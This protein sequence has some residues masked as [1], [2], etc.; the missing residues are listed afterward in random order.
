LLNHLN[1]QKAKMKYQ[2]SWKKFWQ[3]KNKLV[4]KKNELDKLDWRI[5]QAEIVPKNLFPEEDKSAQGE[6]IVTVAGFSYI[7]SKFE[8]FV[9]GFTI[10]SITAM[11]LNISHQSWLEA[12]NI[13]ERHKPF[14][15]GTNTAL[16]IPEE[17]FKDFFNS[18]EKRMQSYIFA[19]SAIEHFANMSIPADYEYLKTNKAGEGFK[20]YKKVDIERYISLD[21]KLSIILPL[22]YKI[23]SFV[24]EPLWQEYLQLKNVRDSLIH[25]KS[26]D[27]QPD[28]WPKVK[29]VWNDLV[30]A[31]K[32]NNPAIISK[33][34]IG[35]Y[36]TNSKN[37]PRWFTK[38]HF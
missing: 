22:I 21:K 38:C 30:F 7:G 34:I 24:S 18:M 36:L 16:Y 2:N 20:V 28:G 32:R 14:K 13:L 12:E 8:K 29:S 11:M 6:E 37:I 4:N 33:K 27:F 35:Y 17:K 31:V 10:P 26:K 9:I 25:F 15:R 19:C 5:Y 1:L 3:E 23:E